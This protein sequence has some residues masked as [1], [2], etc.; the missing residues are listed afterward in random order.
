VKVAAPRMT[1][2]SWA[3]TRETLAAHQ[4]AISALYGNCETLRNA[5][6]GEVIDGKLSSPVTQSFFA[7]REA[8]FWGRLR[9][10]FTG[11]VA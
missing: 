3:E 6:H 5:I 9:W 8:S 10:L 4:E 11:K 7:L 2:M 1:P